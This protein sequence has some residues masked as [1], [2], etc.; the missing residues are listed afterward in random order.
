MRTP[1]MT[2]EMT[3]PDHGD[4]VLADETSVEQLL[5]NLLPTILSA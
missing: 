3:V 5:R 1:D 4:P 2:F